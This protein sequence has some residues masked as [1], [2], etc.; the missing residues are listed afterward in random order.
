M[1][2]GS[3]RFAL[4]ARR[5]RTVIKTADPFA[6]AFAA[7]AAV[8]VEHARNL[9]RTFARLAEQADRA[10]RQALE[11]GWMTAQRAVL[12]AIRRIRGGVARVLFRIAAWVGG[13]DAFAVSVRRESQSVIDEPDTDEINLGSGAT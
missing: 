1:H 7:R 13:S 2:L 6:K 10:A 12:V 3:G 4:D 11:S 9:A 8:L 5:I